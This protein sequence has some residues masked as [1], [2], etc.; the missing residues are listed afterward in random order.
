MHLNKYKTK[1]NHDFMDDAVYKKIS[2]LRKLP[3]Y[4]V[5][6]S[7]AKFLLM[8]NM[9]LSLGSAFEVASRCVPEIKREIAGWNE[10]RRFAMQI[11]PKGP[12]I[13]LAKQGDR[14]RIVGK[15]VQASDVTFMFKNLDAA[16]P[17]FVGLQSTHEAMA[18]SKI[19]IQGDNA[20]AQEFNRAMSLVLANLFPVFAYKHLFKAKPKLG[21][22]GLINKSKVY[23]LLVPQSVV[24]T[25]KH[26][27]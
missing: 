27:K 6:Q 8:D 16:V 12:A 22:K 21:V 13:T 26:F 19:M 18:Q 1:E 7:R 5:M 11:L 10:G 4:P 20:Y 24:N 25:I 23:L 15:G 14:V 9:M 17:V 3:F 2:L